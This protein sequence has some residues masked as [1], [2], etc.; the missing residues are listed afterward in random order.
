MNQRP[1]ELREQRLVFGE[2]AELYER[3][4][5]GYPQ[6]LVDDVLA[7]AGV[8][9]AGCRALE[10]G[11][12]TGKA[13]V[14][15]AA[16]GVAIVA[17]EPDA[18]MGTVLARNCRGFPAVRI[19]E[20]SFEDAPVEAGAFDLVYSA[21]AWHWVGPEVRCVLAAAQLRAGG[22]IALFW[23]RTD[24]GAGDPLR[25]ALDECYRLHAPTLYEKG[26][27]F[28]GLTPAALQSRA[29]EELA[30]CRDF[31]DVTVHHHRW[32]A[33]FTPETFL[34]LLATQS[35]HRLLDD[36]GRATLFDAVRDVLVEHG[37][38]VTVP[39]DILLVLGRRSA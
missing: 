17:V 3:A 18:A 24:W 8:E 21:Q 2:D 19:V 29:H 14:A 16:R 38:S 12:G 31:V 6:S 9:A 37:G 27:G 15:F 35:D 32:R 25:A 7:Y 1:G 34:E 10:V 39:Y 20:A 33:D 11:A 28:P 30:A 5:P 13:T 26:P 4:R 23:H 22:A 36:R